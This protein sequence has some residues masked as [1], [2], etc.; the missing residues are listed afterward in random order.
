MDMN[1]TENNLEFDN[2]WGIIFAWK[3]RQFIAV[4]NFD[5]IRISV[6][7]VETDSIFLSLIV[8]NFFGIL[9]KSW[10]FGNRLFFSIFFI[11]RFVVQIDTVFP[12]QFDLNFDVNLTIVI[13]QR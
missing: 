11:F 9:F 6:K 12:F 13:S 1:L 4:Q 2:K 5:I 8:T 10:L 7:T 3:I